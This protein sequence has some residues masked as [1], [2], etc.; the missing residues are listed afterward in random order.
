MGITIYRKRN[1]GIEIDYLVLSI[2]RFTIWITRSMYINRW[3][4][5][6][7]W[8]HFQQELNVGVEKSWSI[9]FGQD[10]LRSQTRN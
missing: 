1:G 6:I 5:I 9:K 3:P 4:R 7:I 2:W 8:K 10:R